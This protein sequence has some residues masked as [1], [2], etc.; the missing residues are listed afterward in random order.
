[1]RPAGTFSDI[2][3]SNSRI[4]STLKIPYI[5]L[6]TSGHTTLLYDE[7]DGFKNTIIYKKK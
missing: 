3:L 5:G 7:K 2:Q 4:Y 6:G 1:M